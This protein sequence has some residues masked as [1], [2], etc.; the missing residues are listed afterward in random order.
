MRFTLVFQ[1]MKRTH[2]SRLILFLILLGCRLGVKAQAVELHA[3]VTLNNG[4]EQQY[5]LTEEDRFSFEGQETLII[6][7]QGSTVEIDID[8]IRKIEFVDVTGTKELQADSPFFYPN[9]VKKTLFL[10]NIEDGQ[11]VSIYSLEGRLMRQFQAKAHE[12]VNLGDLPTGMYILNL[13]DKNFK[14]LKL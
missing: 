6:N 12:L 1:L 5:Y 11:T 3:L 10:S 9:P 7:T 13:G 14:L 8:D 2:L 4:Q